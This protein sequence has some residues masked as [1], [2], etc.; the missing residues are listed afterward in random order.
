MAILFGP[1]RLDP[2]ERRLSRDG[3]ALDVQDQVIEV[4]VALTGRPGGLW[5]REELHDRLWP[6]AIVSEDALFQALAKTRKALGDPSRQPLYI[7]TVPGHG[8]RFLAEV[9]IEEEPA[10]ASAPAPVAA[11]VFRPPTGLVGRDELLVRLES[12]LRDGAGLWTLTGPGGI[13]KTRLSLEL[14]VRLAS[15]LSGGVV[16]C[17]LQQASTVDE[18]RAAAAYALRVAPQT[19]GEAEALAGELR[20]RGAVLLVLD[21]G[22]QVAAELAQVCQALLQAAPQA[23]LLVTSRVRLGLAGEHLVEL[24]VLALPPIEA[25][26]D[27][28]RASSAGALLLERAAEIGFRAQPVHALA[29]AALTHRLGGLPLALELAAPRLRL[30]SPEQLLA[31]MDRHLDLLGATLGARPARHASMRSAIASSWELLD[32]PARR[33]L[34]QLSVVPG[35]FTAELAEA[36]LAREEDPLELLATL[37]DHSLVHRVDGE[38]P[39]LQLMPGIRDFAAEQLSDRGA[40]LDR[41]AEWL[42]APGT[43]DPHPDRAGVQAGLLRSTL[44]RVYEHARAAGRVELAARLAAAL[45]PALLAEGPLQLA[46]RICAEARQAG[47]LPPALTRRLAC[48]EAE[49]RLQ[50]FETRQV[51]ELLDLAQALGADPEV[52]RLRVFLLHHSGSIEAAIELGLAA[53]ERFPEPTPARVGLLL[54]TA[55]AERYGK[56]LAASQAHLDEAATIIEAHDLRKARVAACIGQSVLSFSR[57]EVRESLERG[58]QALAL[59]EGGPDRLDQATAHER[60]GMALIFLGQLDEA[61]LHLAEAERLARQAGSTRGVAYAV[62]GLARLATF[63][64]DL[65][66]GERLYRQATEAFAEAGLA[67]IAAVVRG[68]LGQLL[69]RMGK[70]DEAEAILLQAQAGQ[71]EAKIDVGFVLHNL[72]MVSLLRGDL[73]LARERMLAGMEEHRRTGNARAE[74]LSRG[75]LAQIELAAGNAAGAVQILPAVIESLAAQDLHQVRARMQGLLGRALSEVGRAQEAR[76]AFLAGE[77]TLRERSMQEDLGLLLCRRGRAH[78]SW[79]ETDEARACEAEAAALARIC[80]SPEDSELGRERR[81]LA[82]QLSSFNGSAG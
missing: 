12:E 18:V 38:P 62:E 58:R 11:P 16:V 68:N 23:R 37:V 43:F 32:A 51:A 82:A 35:P 53:L 33:S 30:L 45:A 27:A 19:L 29:L 81:E 72:G 1:F 47:P 61:G 56:L 67:A 36:L 10:P 7:A 63:R 65:S 8:Y 9:R 15:E 64:G 57:G 79:A 59:L 60:V 6:D 74:L 22:E 80:G 20:S 17:D 4:L 46:A 55:S 44:L 2:A 39:R 31:R 52:D 78:L 24:P 26:L 28:L 3:V 25:D 5:T 54:A 14:G 69:A 34:A 75:Y 70:L 66:T 21:N 49:A 76:A 13:G 48:T 40:V 77:E 73:D 42:V 50:L 41:L 71:L